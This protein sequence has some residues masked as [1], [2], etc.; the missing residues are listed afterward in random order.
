MD[1]EMR[2]KEYWYTYL[3]AYLIGIPFVAVYSALQIYVS[4]GTFR[5]DDIGYWTELLP[6]NLLA[7]SGVYL[8]I[9]GIMYVFMRKPQ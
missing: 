3:C 5:I 8:I 1:G 4:W 6:Y 9:L 7:Y 2:F